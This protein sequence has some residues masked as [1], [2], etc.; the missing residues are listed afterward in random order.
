M[1]LAALALAASMALPL[2]VPYLGGRVNDL[3]DMIPAD[4]EARIEARLERLESERG[5]QVAVLTIPSLEGEV[6]EYYSLR[7]AET[8]ALGRGEFDDGALLLIA[9]DDRKMR[10]EVG[11]GLEPTI[12]D[13]ASRRILDDVLRPRFRAGDFAGGIE[14]AVNV[15]AGL[16]EGDDLLPPPGSGSSEATES[17]ARRLLGFLIPVGFF[18]LM[19][20]ASSGCSG[21]VLYLIL[22]PVWFVFPLSVF[23]SPWGF[24]PGILWMLGFPILWSLVGRRAR[25]WRSKGGWSS[26]RGGWTGGGFSGGGF[27][28]GG[29]S[30]GGGSFGGG[31]SS[32]SW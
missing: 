9:R 21:W 24:V 10:L 7:V 27:S 26:T 11:Y 30:G 6:L 15:V 1:W 29:F 23:G 8:W 5:S 20:I 32:G 16:I 12:T 22:A 25:S 31:G 14:E 2:E 13:L 18:S 17:T 28:G 19:A 3:A 4:T